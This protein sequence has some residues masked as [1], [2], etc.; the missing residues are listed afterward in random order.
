MEYN[1]HNQ[2]LLMIDRESLKKYNLNEIVKIFHEKQ[3]KRILI[4]KSGVFL[5]SVMWPIKFLLGA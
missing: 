3:N 2:Y 4:N 1:F 5:L